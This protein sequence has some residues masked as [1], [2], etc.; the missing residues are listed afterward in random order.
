MNNGNE[1]RKE[2]IK[3]MSTGLKQLNKYLHQKF[4]FTNI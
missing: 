3:I 1:E 2:K 4:T